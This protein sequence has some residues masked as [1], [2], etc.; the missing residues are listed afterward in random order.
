MSEETPARPGI[1]FFWLNDEKLSE[2][3]DG[4]EKKRVR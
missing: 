4:T 3:V 1:S 2:V